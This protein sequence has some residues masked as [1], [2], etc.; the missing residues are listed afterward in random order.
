MASD[1]R[2][3]REHPPTLGFHRGRVARLKFLRPAI[4]AVTVIIL[5]PLASAAYA[6]N[7]QPPLKPTW[8]PLV[9]ETFGCIHEDWTEAIWQTLARPQYRDLPFSMALTIASTDEGECK[10]FPEGQRVLIDNA[11]IDLLEGF[12]P[13]RLS[14]DK[15]WYW[16]TIGAMFAETPPDAYPK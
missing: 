7:D 8:E 9:Q 12:G 16:I 13:I 5:I 10:I 11:R 4:T 2:N 3:K 14:N 6:Q 1:G 15:Q